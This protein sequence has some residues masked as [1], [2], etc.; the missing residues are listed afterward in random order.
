MSAVHLAEQDLEEIWFCVAEDASPTTADR[1]IDAIFNRFEMFV[2]QPRMGR[3][4]SSATAFARSS[5]RAT[6]STIDTMR[7]S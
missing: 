5:S 6:S 3:S 7:I 2:E 1:L 4:Q